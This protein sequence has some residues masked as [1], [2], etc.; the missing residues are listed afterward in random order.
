MSNEPKNRRLTDG[1]PRWTPRGLAVEAIREWWRFQLRSDKECTQAFYYVLDA[2]TKF[3]NNESGK[4][5]PGKKLLAAFGCVSP[6][7]VKRA[8][9]WAVTRGHLKRQHRRA[10]GAPKNESNVLTPVL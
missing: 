4:A 6:S 7:S 5:F 8:V 9:E 3:Q 2:V 1:Q 10:K